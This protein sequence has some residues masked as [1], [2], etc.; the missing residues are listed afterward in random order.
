M[1][2][3]SLAVSNIHECN[4]CGME[5]GGLSTAMVIPKLSCKHPFRWRILFARTL[6]LCNT[7]FI[8]LI[9]FAIYLAYPSH[10]SSQSNYIIQLPRPPRGIICLIVEYLLLSPHLCSRNSRLYLYIHF[11]TGHKNNPFSS[12]S[13]SVCLC[14]CEAVVAFVMDSA[15]KA[16]AEVDIEDGGRRS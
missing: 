14:P 11:L 4:I 13:G 7:T 5:R 3:Y 10:L 9:F 15:I 12:G 6:R 2:R 16:E 1:W 8:F